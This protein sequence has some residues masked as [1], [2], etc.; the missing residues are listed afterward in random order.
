[1]ELADAVWRQVEPGGEAHVEH[2]VRGID[3]VLAA[4]SAGMERLFSSMSTGEQLVLRAAAHGDS[5]FG[6]YNIRG[7]QHCSLFRVINSH[8]NCKCR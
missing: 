1:M 6:W 2:V 7:K 4:G 5:I 3:G 8:I